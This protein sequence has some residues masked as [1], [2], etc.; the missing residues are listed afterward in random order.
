MLFTH[1]LF[2]AYNVWMV[3]D[4]LDTQ[5][6]F[7]PQGSG[8]AWLI[9]LKTPNPLVGKGNPR[10]GRLYKA[11]I[12]ESLG[13]IHSLTDARKRRDIILGQIRQNEAQVIGE[14]IGSPEDAAKWA[15]YVS[16]PSPETIVMTDTIQ[17]NDGPLEIGI[18]EQ[19]M[20]M[21]LAAERALQIQKRHG[22]NLF[23]PLVT[24]SNSLFLNPLVSLSA[25]REFH[26]EIL[27]R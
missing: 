7:Q 4:V 23:H 18:S 22:A 9:R 6:L 25:V 3:D 10:T 26:F 8:T 14:Q 15:E 21:E 13:G 1:L 20:L 17:I 16:E 24:H 12:R 27:Y 2:A 19:E 5:Y 11:E